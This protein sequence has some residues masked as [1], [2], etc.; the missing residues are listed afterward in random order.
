MAFRGRF[1]KFAFCALLAVGSLAGTPMRPEEI[2]ELMS[3]MNQPKA[4]HTLPES[5]ENGDDLL[6][7]LGWD[8]SDL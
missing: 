8:E 5:N 4:A 7:N 3:T 6:R 2:E 1:C